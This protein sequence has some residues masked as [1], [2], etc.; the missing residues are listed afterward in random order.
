LKG[1]LISQLDS[2]PLPLLHLDLIQ[3]L[4]DITRHIMRL[5]IYTT[6]QKDAQR[7]S[8]NYDVH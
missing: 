5:C 2:D 7:D 4:L 1:R 6:A 8:R 3:D